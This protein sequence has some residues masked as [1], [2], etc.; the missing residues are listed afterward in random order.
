MGPSRRNPSGGGGLWSISSSLVVDDVPTSPPSRSSTSPHKSPPQISPDLWKGA[1]TTC[2]LRG[3]C[4]EVEL[5][6]GKNPNHATFYS[7]F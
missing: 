5:L 7:H 2:L 4:N 6:R 3:I 1:L